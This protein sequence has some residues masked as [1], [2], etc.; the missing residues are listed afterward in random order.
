MNSEIL[1]L[2]LLNLLFKASY[3]FQ[4]YDSSNVD[5]YDFTLVQT[6]TEHIYI[7]FMLYHNI[8]NQVKCCIQYCMLYS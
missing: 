4:H 7:M 6:D 5:F 8:D 3:K 1:Y 2:S